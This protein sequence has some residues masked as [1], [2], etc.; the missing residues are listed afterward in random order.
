M[1]WVLVI[2]FLGIVVFGFF[3][4]KLLDGFLQKNGRPAEE[5]EK[6]E[7]KKTS[8]KSDDSGTDEKR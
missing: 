6:K 4:M 3:V 1:D 2:I 8:S 5:Y 7:K